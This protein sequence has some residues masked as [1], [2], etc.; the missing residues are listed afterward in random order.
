MT[1]RLQL[2]LLM[3]KNEKRNLI[4]KYCGRKFLS[5][6]DQ[7]F[8]D[9]EDFDILAGFHYLERQAR[10]RMII[11]SKIV[12][13]EQRIKN[14]KREIGATSSEHSK[15]AVLRE[16]KA[17][18]CEKYGVE[19]VYSIWLTDKSLEEGEQWRELTK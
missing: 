5:Q 19:F 1:H 8:D 7:N 6:I 4:D 18:L 12:L 14:K 13:L 15:E 11:C 9:V 16:L 2:Q 10:D 17:E 3:L